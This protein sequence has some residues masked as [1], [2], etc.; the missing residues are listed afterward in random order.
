VISTPQ[1]RS[2]RRFIRSLGR[3]LACQSGSSLVE[4]A[5]AAAVYFSLFFGVI[6]TCFALY[7]FNF[8]S[9]AAREATRYAM[10]RGANSCLANAAFPDCNLLPT[11][12]TSSTDSTH[13]PVLAYIDSTNYPGLDPNRMSAT[14]TWWVATQTTDAGGNPTTVWTTPCTTAVDANGNA[15]NAPGNAVNVVVTY[16]FPL[17]IPW[18]KSSLVKVSST[19]QMVINF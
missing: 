14:V 1:K 16:G 19:S 2:V 5:V 13:N 4:F 7:T 15:C 11:N 3:A 18:W 12:I 9:D 10:V 17:S 6:E 8:V